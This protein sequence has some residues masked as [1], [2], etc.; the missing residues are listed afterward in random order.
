MEQ[1][2]AQVSQQYGDHPVRPEQWGGYRLVPDYFEFWQ[3]RRSRF[4]TGL[5]ISCRP[6]VRGSGSGCNPKLAR[7]D[8]R[9]APP[10]PHFKSSR[11]LRCAATGKH[12]DGIW[13]L[14]AQSPP[15]NSPV[16]GVADNS[17]GDALR[18]GKTGQALQSGSQSAHPTPG[19]GRLDLLCQMLL[20]LILIKN[21]RAILWPDI[22]TLP[23]QRGWVVH[24]KKDS[25]K[26][27][28]SIC[29]ESKQIRT[30]SACPL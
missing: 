4:L 26:V 2:L 13:P 17:F 18:P 8:L 27:R 23:V 1:R 14:W 10:R 30:T 25:S 5:C 7:P 6:M 19:H 22:I 20:G 9:S 11:R 16:P 29:A 24:G 12:P 28:A 3:G 15:R 21:H